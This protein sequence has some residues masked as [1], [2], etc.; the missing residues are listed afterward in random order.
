MKRVATRKTEAA[1]A[2]EAAKA[3][4]VQVRFLRND[5]PF[6][7]GDVK[8]CE[9]AEADKFVRQGV[10]ERIHA[11]DVPYDEYEVDLG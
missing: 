4:W 5:S 7:V 2:A 8:I 10:A 3:E 1:M 6:R 9:P 11:D